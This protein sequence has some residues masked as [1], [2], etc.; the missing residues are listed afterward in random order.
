MGSGRDD[1]SA[2]SQ[3]ILMRPPSKQLFENVLSDTQMLLILRKY[4]K[5][6]KPWN[7]SISYILDTSYLQFCMKFP[8]SNA[9]LSLTNLEKFSRK[10]WKTTSEIHRLLIIKWST[11]KIKTVPVCPLAVKVLIGFVLN[12]SPY[13]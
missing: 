7:K 3:K 6:V 4:Q 5:F 8:E 13:W 2:Q 11:F 9:K 1:C 10:N 12:W